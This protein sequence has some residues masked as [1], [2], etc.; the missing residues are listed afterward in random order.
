MEI[1]ILEL[2]NFMKIYR[3]VEMEAGKFLSISAYA[4]K[5]KSL[6]KK[7]AESTLKAI[8]EYKKLPTEIRAELEKDNENY[9]S[10]IDEVERLCGEAKQI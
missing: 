7:S 1:N 6:K 9:V 4:M 8:G 2:A 5:N 10:K 3:N